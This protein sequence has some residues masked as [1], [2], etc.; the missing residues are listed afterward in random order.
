MH[1]RTPPGN[2]SDFTKFRISIDFPLTIGGHAQVKIGNTPCKYYFS[3][4]S[5]FR[6][7][8]ETSP[9]ILRNQMSLGQLKYG[10]PRERQ[11]HPAERRSTSSD[12][13][14]N[15]QYR[16]HCRC[17]TEFGGSTPPFMDAPKSETRLATRSNTAFHPPDSDEFSKTKIRRNQ[18]VK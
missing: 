13:S 2:D 1:R 9:E 7:F 3:W 11:S 6:E 14:S 5:N 17:C 8:A 18:G 16:T 4:T 10:Q 12:D 15:P